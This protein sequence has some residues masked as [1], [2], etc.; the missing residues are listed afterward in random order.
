MA[1]RR[2]GSAV[3]CTALAV[4]IFPPGCRS[5]EGQTLSSVSDPLPMSYTS[6][7]I[8][9]YQMMTRLFGNKNATNKM[10]G[11]IGENGVGKFEDISVKALSELRDLGA[12][13]IWY[14]GVIEHATMTTYPAHGISIDDV[15]VVKGRAGS[16]YAIKDYYDVNPDLATDVSKRKDEFKSLI[17]RTH[18]QGLKVLID[19]VPNHVA[20]NYVSDAS[21]MGVAGFGDNDD[22]AVHFKPSN[23][24]YYM[25]GQAFKVPEGYDPF[26]GESNPTKDGKFNEY[27]AKATGNDV[28]ISSPSINDWFETVKLNYGVDYQN[29]RATYFDPVPDT[30]TK[31]YDMLA[32]WTR[33][34]VDGFRCDM[35]EMVPVE[36]WE[37]VI[38][39]VK[40]INSDILF[41]A[42]IYN[43]NEYRNYIFK[44]HFD[45]LYDKVELYDTL[46]HI[47]EGKANTDHITSIWQRQEGIGS[48]M[49]RFLENHDEQRIASPFFANKPEYAIPAMVLTAT[50]H[51]GPVMVY[52][53]Q[54]VGEPGAGKEGFQGEDGRTTIFDYWG[55]PAHQRWMN[56]GKF[57]GGK[58]TESEKKLREAYKFIL[59]ISTKEDMIA[60]GGFYDLHYYNR[61]SDFQGYSDQVFA[62]LRHDE[63]SA[64]LIAVNF[65]KSEKETVT[66]KVPGDALDK[67]RLSDAEEIEFVDYTNK[68][69]K[70]TASKNDLTDLFSDGKL[71]FEIES[72]SFRI[73]SLQ[74]K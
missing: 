43:P 33:F 30:W 18:N 44:G 51:T 7:K 17:E 54:E 8:I 52:F 15:D 12:T 61:R 35:A 16:P 59:N 2:L 49:L 25:P 23:N 19:C 34:G 67:F 21:P 14:T 66:V 28:F 55:V 6:D 31:M 62:F 72:C 40:D 73:F 45:Y 3:V 42:E 20:R 47:V 60:K 38:P 26:P 74:S 46:R 5:P 13:H 70:Y 63:K 36:F 58:L 32:Y 39:K 41:I 10:Y 69:V 68:K 37:W 57:D 27:P 22:T 4:L 1:F 65:N 9:I 24:F 71:T 48:Y 64:L 56:E 53:G 11:T 29:G 50:M